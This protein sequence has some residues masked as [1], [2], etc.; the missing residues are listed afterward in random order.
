M[1]GTVGVVI[2]TYNRKDLLINCIKAIS[3]QTYL[4]TILYIIDNDSNDGT[5]EILLENNIIPNLP[6]KNNSKDQIIEH[7]TQS[8]NDGK[9]PLKVKYIRKYKN[10]GGAGGFYEGMKQAFED[11]NDWIWMMD[12]DGYASKTCLEKLIAAANSFSLKAI[13]P[14]VLNKAEHEDLSFG[15]RGSRKLREI[16]KMA[17]ENGLIY[18]EANPFNGTLFNR[19]LILKC[20]YVKKEMFIWGDE[21][22]Y[23][24]RIEKYN[25]K[26]ATSIESI[27]YHP[28][29][30][31]SNESFLWGLINVVSKPRTLEMNFYR[32]IGYLN[33]TYRNRIGI[34]TL[35]KYT[36][37]FI[38]KLDVRRGLL[39][40]RYYF[41]GLNDKYRLPNRL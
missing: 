38:L 32:N 16:E 26:Y 2:V 5:P 29:S 30:K 18:Q 12:D 13:N 40:F 31:T 8:I 36:V 41:D 33:K 35:I 39:F 14:I 3:E 23:F 9:T 22:E 19:D 27:F 6:V 20:G 11:D 4:P 17:D 15:L 1:E 28:E 7:Q 24:Y 25:F 34:K 10:E 21:V 37:Y